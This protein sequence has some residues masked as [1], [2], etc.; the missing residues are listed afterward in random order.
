MARGSATAQSTTSDGNAVL[1]RGARVRGSVRGEGNLVIEG[2]VEGDVTITGDLAISD[3]GAI[4]GDIDA[5][6]VTIGGA[7]TGDVAAKGAVMIRA[8][9]K[10]VG[11]MG[12]AEVSIEEGASFVGRIEAE[13]D[14]PAEL[15]A[16]PGAR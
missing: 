15:Q 14:L 5:A 1:G 9:A 8:G 11:S 7:L 3:G 16:R 2:Q 12:G 4:T 10:V 13:F 6:A